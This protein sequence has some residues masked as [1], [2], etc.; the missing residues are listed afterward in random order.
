MQRSQPFGRALDMMAL[1]SAAMQM[2]A[3]EKQAAMQAIG[4]YVSRG[5]GRGKGKS[6]PHG[7]QM[8]NI[9]AARKARNV[10]RH[11]ARSH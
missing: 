3:T 4:P 7:A 8:A 1:I 11:R 10:R 2:P 5:K 6:A 9:R